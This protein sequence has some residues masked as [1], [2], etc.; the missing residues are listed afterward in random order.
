MSTLRLVLG[1]G[2]VPKQAL[3]VHGRV[4]ELFGSFVTSTFI[5]PP[6]EKLVQWLGDYSW[7]FSI[8]NGFGSVDSCYL[9]ILFLSLIGIA[10]FNFWRWSIMTSREINFSLLLSLSPFPLCLYKYVVYAY[11][12]DSYLIY[13]WIIFLDGWCIHFAYMIGIV[14]NT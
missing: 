9:S 3:A 5:S 2:L 8:W 10:C 13:T 6:R 4:D 11:W 12:I 14:F 1:L 7:T